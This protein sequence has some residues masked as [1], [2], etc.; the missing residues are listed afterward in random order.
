MWA[1]LAKPGMVSP[2]QGRLALVPPQSSPTA[3]RRYVTTAGRHGA[4]PAPDT[5]EPTCLLHQLRQICSGSSGRGTVRRPRCNYACGAQ[6]LEGLS[7]EGFPSCWAMCYPAGTRSN[8]AAAGCQMPLQ[9]LPL[10]R[11]APTPALP[12]PR[13]CHG[14]SPLSAASTTTGILTHPQPRCTVP[15]SDSFSRRLRIILEDDRFPRSPRVSCSQ[16]RPV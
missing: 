16:P 9:G 1:E 2:N 4:H 5:A 12:L 6:A 10:Y 7:L 8:S 11:P 15:R 13:L 3:G 14:Q